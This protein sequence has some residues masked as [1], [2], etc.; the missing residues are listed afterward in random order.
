MVLPRQ[1][2][3]QTPPMALEV[4]VEFATVLMALHLPVVQVVVAVLKLE[5][6]EVVVILVVAVVV[7]DQ[8]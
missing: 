5:E 4:L 8:V 2:E 1:P 7:V 6:A 3:G